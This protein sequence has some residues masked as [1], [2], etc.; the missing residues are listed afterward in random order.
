MLNTCIVL[1]CMVLMV[2]HQLAGS[3]MLLHTCLPSLLV[4]LY[5]Q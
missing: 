4:N 3:R 1:V 2:I 5:M